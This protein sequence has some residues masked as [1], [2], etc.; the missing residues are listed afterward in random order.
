MSWTLRVEAHHT[1]TCEHD[2]VDAFEQVL[3]QLLDGPPD[4]ARVFVDGPWS[5]ALGDAVRRA[6]EAIGRDFRVQHLT[7]NGA[8]N[9][10]RGRDRD[11]TEV[12]DPEFHTLLGQIR[13]RAALLEIYGEMHRGSLERDIAA[14]RRRFGGHHAQLARA[15]DDGR[16]QGVARLQLKALIERHGPESSVVENRL[17]ELMR[18]WPAA[19][20]TFQNDLDAALAKAG[21]PLLPPT[22]H[23]HRVYRLPPSPRWHIYI[24]ETGAEFGAKSRGAIWAVLVPDHLLATIPRPSGSFHAV[25]EPAHVIDR[26][27]ADLLAHPIGL[28]GVDARAFAPISDPVRRWLAGV[29]ELVDWIIR[30]LPLTSEGRVE[31]NIH[32]EQRGHHPAGEV[33]EALPTA[34]LAQLSRYHGDRADRLDIAPIA[35]HAKDAEGAWVDAIAHTWG[36]SGED[37]GRRRAILKLDRFMVGVHGFDMRRLFD[38]GLGL[39]DPPVAIWRRLVHAAPAH[40]SAH[41]IHDLL[42]RLSSIAR[43]DGVLWRR[44]LGAT[45]A[46]MHGTELDIGRLGLEVAWLDHALPPAHTL[47]PAARL[48]WALAVV[49]EENHVGDMAPDG[50]LRTIHHLTSMLFDEDPTLAAVADLHVAAV[51][52][53]RFAFAE[54]SAALSRWQGLPVSVGGL[55]V[56]GRIWASLG[57]HAGFEGRFAEAEEHFVAALQLF[58]RLS[59]PGEA[60]ADLERTRIYRAIAAMDDPSTNDMT[61]RCRLEEAL[62]ENLADAVRTFA[63]SPSH[64][65][66]HLFHAVCRYAASA[67]EGAEALREILAAFPAPPLDAAH[68]ADADVGMVGFPWPLIWHYR[69]RFFAERGQARRAAGCDTLARAAVDRLATPGPALR[70]IVAVLEAAARAPHTAA[71]DPEALDLEALRSAMPE[72]RARID[73]LATALHQGDAAPTTLVQRLLPFNFR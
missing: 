25:S 72:A 6:R 1:L 27:L 45:L 65:T 29:T 44:L 18:R 53:N 19:R 43:N 4:E 9:Q 21:S 64:R 15:L 70:F 37:A 12:E 42:D 52:T 16:Q 31:L 17:R 61:A 39:G 51:H 54:A 47:N 66:R 56:H 34:L 3:L 5:Q 38:L 33:W 23:D 73:A 20:R 68:V 40:P 59:D 2:D 26:A 11:H 63:A 62:G 32:V 24:D 36:G 58:A 57:Q 13:R 67:R 14:F 71:V 30:L 28:L 10:P 55:R 41:L 46:A 49:A 8:S 22:H 7:Q 48:A 50:P 69:G 35:V 60:A